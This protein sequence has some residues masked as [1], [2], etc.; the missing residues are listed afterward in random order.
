MRA[1]RLVEALHH[2]AHLTAGSL[3]SVRRLLAEWATAAGL[4]SDMVDAV[5][6]SGYEALAN[7]VEH[8]YGM[9]I[10]G[11]VELEATRVGDVVTLTVADRGR[12]QVPSSAP[13]GRG[14]GLTLVRGLAD[15]SDVA[16][17]DLGT[18][19]R[20]TWLLDGHGQKGTSD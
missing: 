2:R 6:L 10:G 16:G 17:T 20:M 15:R 5:V 13:G 1:K 4:D 9:A 19:V 18:T 7:S 8:A 12:W 14:R 3:S 11:V